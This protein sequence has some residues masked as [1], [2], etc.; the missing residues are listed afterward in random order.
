MQ[1]EIKRFINYLKEDVRRNFLLIFILTSIF[2]YF[3]YI[4]Y[5][6]RFTINSASRFFG[7]IDKQAESIMTIYD[8]GS[9]ILVIVGLLIISLQYGETNMQ[10]I[11][12]LRLTTPV[13]IIE[14]SM[15]LAINLG[16]ILPIIGTFSLYVGI[17]F[18]RQVQSV[19]MLNDINFE[20]P[21]WSFYDVIPLYFRYLTFVLSIGAVLV[22]FRRYMVF[23][24]PLLYIIPIFYSIYKTDLYTT[25]IY[26]RNSSLDN[27]EL[28][29]DKIGIYFMFSLIIMG[30]ILIFYVYKERELKNNL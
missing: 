5:F 20:A 10:N 16:I 15:S 6:T 2:S 17:N 13:S 25:L 4:I 28:P 29:S 14:K 21:I 11:R 24:L 26:P 9:N 30:V 23:L 27:L 8:F 19:M 18:L 3:G 22:Y 7:A 1:F 12:R